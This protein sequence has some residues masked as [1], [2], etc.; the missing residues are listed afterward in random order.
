M[1]QYNNGAINKF[2]PR[3]VWYLTSNLCKILINGMMLANGHIIENK[4]RRYDTSSKKLADDFQRLCLHAKFA[5]NITIKYKNNITHK[6]GEKIHS[7][8][9]VYRMTIIETH[10]EPLINK[11]VNLGKVSDEM[12]NYKGMVY[13]CSAK[14]L[15][16][17]YVRK[18]YKPIWIGNCSRHGQKGT[19]GILLPS[20]DMPYT[21]SGIQPDI[22]INPCCFS[23]STLIS[24]NN[25]LSRR[26]ES[27]SNQGLEK[28]LTF[29]DKV[30]GIIESFSLGM[31]S[32]GIKETIKLTLFDGREIICTPDHK[33]KVKINNEYIY[34][35]AKDLIENSDNLIIGPDYTEDIKYDDEHNWSL[36]IDDY[37]FDMKN[38]KNRNKSLAFAR[39]LGLLHADGILTIDKQSI[40]LF[41]SHITDIKTISDDIELI[42]NIKCTILTDKDNVYFINIPDNFSKF[43]ANL[44]GMTVGKITNQEASLPIFLSNENLPKAFIREFLGGYFGGNA[45]SPHLIKNNF[46]TVYLS[47]TICKKFEDSL[48]NKINIIV[49]LLDKIGVESTVNTAKTTNKYNQTY[50]DKQIIQVDIYTKSN[51]QFLNKIGFRHC[52]F[53]TV[54]LSLAASYERYSNKVKEQ[55]DKIFHLVNEKI[56]HQKLYRTKIFTNCKKVNVETALTEARLECYQF[57]K[58]INEYYSLLTIDLVNK[59]IRSKRSMK[60]L[61][62]NYKF[63]STAKEYLKQINCEEWFIRVNV[64]FNYMIKKNNDFIPTWNIKLFNKQQNIDLEVFDIGVA[65]THNFLASGIIVSN[66]IP[67]R[68]TI[69]QLF[70]SVFSKVASIR[71]EMLD[72]TPFNNL[73][74]NK[75]TDEL[76]EYGFDEHGY[77][78][79]YCGMTG[80]KMLSKIFIGPTFYLRLKHMVQDKIH[81][82]ATGPKQRL[83]HQPPEGRARDGG[84]R[85]GEMERDA[86]ISHGC[87]L[88]L[89]ERLVDTSDI[90]SCYVC[91][92]CGLIASK[93]MD[94]DI[95]IYAM[96]VINYLNIKQILHM[97]LK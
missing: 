47:Q 59:R 49:K 6:I 30:E 66:C 23:G 45:Q 12:I 2:L 41:I 61:N 93:K 29:D 85:F 53:K 46:K 26:I 31:E 68:M 69:G 33:F 24:L 82:R 1:F 80:K 74:F 13:C 94:K 17:I 35:E 55:H 89:K 11:N 5:T 42:I 7:T 65:N 44:E 84:L 72:A 37:I 67:S 14:Y 4:T 58:P 77:E 70:E 78:H 90:Y 57:D 36:N 81:S 51:L 62:F 52:V 25:G 27:F 56:K 95:Y 92:K 19:I 87:S 43:I 28:L 9:D 10:N 76:K 22:I 64:Q 83:T 21:E 79:L 3:W 60:L 32:K 88:F 75:V 71:G 16:I 73:D 54:R 48:I 38:E 96:H 15:G 91:S 63:F 39:I 86:M 34:K 50:I 40:Q 97:L 8:V 20:T 18:N